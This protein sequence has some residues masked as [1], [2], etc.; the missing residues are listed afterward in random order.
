[1]KTKCLIKGAT[2]RS[3]ASLSDV[4]MRDGIMQSWRNA[5]FQ[6]LAKNGCQADWSVVG[7]IRVIALLKDWDYLCSAPIRWGSTPM[8]AKRE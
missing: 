7:W 5:A 8:P 1:M 3:K 2:T 4:K 6:N